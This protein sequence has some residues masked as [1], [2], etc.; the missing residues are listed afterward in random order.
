ME[1]IQNNSNLAFGLIIVLVLAMLYLVC[2][3]R[4]WLGSA[5]EPGKAT[6]PSHRVSHST[7]NSS[8]DSEE[9]SELDRMIQEINS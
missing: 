7:S 1:L 2:Q 5:F 9:E 3:Q 6:P 8:D 4:G